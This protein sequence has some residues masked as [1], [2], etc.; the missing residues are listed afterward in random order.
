MNNNYGLH[1]HVQPLG[2]FDMNPPHQAKPSL[3]GP[4]TLG[5]GIHGPWHLNPGSPNFPNHRPY[6]TN[7]KP[8]NPAAPVPSQQLKTT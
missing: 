6:L 3:A 4:K 1:I 7:I 2:G 8:P 5:L